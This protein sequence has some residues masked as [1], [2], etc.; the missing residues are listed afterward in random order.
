MKKL[1]DIYINIPVKSIAKAYTYIIPEKFDILKEGCRVLVPF[2]NRIMEGFII[3]IYTNNEHNIDITKLKEIK[4]II[5]TEAWFTP[6]MYTTAKWMADFYL[7]SVGETMRLFIPGKNSVQIRPI[8][9]INQQEYDLFPKNK[10]S[11]IEI[12]LLE[13]LSLQKNTDLLTLRHKFST[14]DNLSSLLDKL[15]AKN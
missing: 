3:K 8:F 5:D 9:N 1:A 11:P 2:G 6:Q 10:L 14:I 4:D 13:Y 12:S 7:C 15:I